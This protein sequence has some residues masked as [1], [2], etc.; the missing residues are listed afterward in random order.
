MRRALVV[1]LAGW[2][3]AATAHAARRP[4]T[5]A[6]AFAV[7]AVDEIRISPDASTVGFSV[8]STDLR[9]NRTTT[10][11]MRVAASGGTPTELEGVP[12]D[13]QRLRWSPDSPR[14]PLF[15]PAP[16]P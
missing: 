3:G 8:I 16:P 6:D 5:P 14:L 7:Q 10:H 15:A 11:V 1:L 9:A 4:M 2:A 13:A 12:R